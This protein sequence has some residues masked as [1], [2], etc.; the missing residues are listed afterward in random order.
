MTPEEPPVNLGPA[1]GAAE[2]AVEPEQNAALEQTAEPEFLAPL[3]PPPERDPFW[4]YSDL[5]WFCGLVIPC[6]LAGEALEWLTL[7]LFKWNVTS[8]AVRSLSLIHI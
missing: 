8:L 3:P 6:M 2:A 7:A 4:G 5:L 1:S